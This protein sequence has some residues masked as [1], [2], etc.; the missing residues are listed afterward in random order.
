MRWLLISSI[1]LGSGILGLIVLGPGVTGISSEGVVTITPDRALRHDIRA[2]TSSSDIE[3][4]IDR[5]LSRKSYEEALM[6]RDIALFARLPLRE[7]T[8]KA[9]SVAT[10][11][12]PSPAF[13]QDTRPQA[14]KIYRILAME[15]SK[16]VA[17]ESF[18]QFA[19][20]LAVAN[21]SSQPAD[22]SIASPERGIDLIHSAH[23]SQTLHADFSAYIKQLVEE[24]VDFGDVQNALT[25]TRIADRSATFASLK[26]QT[27]GMDVTE[28][29]SVSEGI[30]TL[31]ER[32]GAEY[33][34]PL[35][36][37]IRSPEDLAALLDMSQVLKSQTYGIVKLTGRT[38]LS[39]LPTQIPF[40]DFALRNMLAF[41]I[42]TSGL[43]LVL[44]G[45]QIFRSR[46][47]RLT[48][49]DDPEPEPIDPKLPDY[50]K[51]PKIKKARV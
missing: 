30:D 45:R 14:D 6:Y 44:V 19:L 17:G 5:A 15:G 42:W 47:R 51:N 50:V 7:E 18:D 2:S 41:I 9:L 1:L 8:V 39:N 35:M 11:S 4:E 32:V 12:D 31:R 26:T 46:W 21:L 23:M 48:L 40:E 3:R 36:G 33:A 28:L 16:L 25:S 20:G 10:Q 24:T 22:G 13:E 43:L 27:S 49:D 29:A 37:Y 38:S 34:V